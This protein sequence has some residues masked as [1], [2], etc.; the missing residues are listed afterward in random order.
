MTDKSTNP[1]GDPDC[2]IS[3]GVCDN[4]TFGKGELD[5]NGYWEFP[6]QKCADAFLAENGSLDTEVLYPSEGGTRR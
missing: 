5:P 2:S 1:C 4:L 3:T 6:C